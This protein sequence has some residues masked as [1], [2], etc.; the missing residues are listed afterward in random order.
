MLRVTLFKSSFSKSNVILSGCVIFCC[1]V[2]V[3]DDAWSEAV[4]FQRAVFFFPAVTFV[5]RGGC[6]ACFED[7]SVVLLNYGL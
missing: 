4:V 1:C 2:G 5:F 7:F 3:V 6:L